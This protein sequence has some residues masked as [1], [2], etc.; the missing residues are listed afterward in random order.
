MTSKHS[1]VQTRPLTATTDVSAPIPVKP[2]YVKRAPQAPSV[3]FKYWQLAY[4]AK[5]KGITAVEA[6]VPEVELDA[7]VGSTEHRA[8]VK[9]GDRFFTEWTAQLADKPARTYEPRVTVTA[10]RIEA[11]TTYLTTKGLTA[12]E[13]AEAVA[14]ALPPRK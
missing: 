2:A 3:Q 6:G 5:A 11:L 7:L 14:I 12:Q 8:L 9:R 1:T 13:C 4:N 10:Q